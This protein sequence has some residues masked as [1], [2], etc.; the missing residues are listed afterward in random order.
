MRSTE[1]TIMKQYIVDAFTSELFSGNPAAVVI[2]AEPISDSL[3]NKIAAENNLSETAFAVKKA[4]KG[5]SDESVYNLR[6]IT[7]NGEIDLC[8][9]A[10]LATAFVISNFYE[11]PDKGHSN[12]GKRL[13]SFSTRSGLLTVSCIDDFYELNFPSFPLEKIDITPIM[14]DALGTKPVDAVLGRDL[15][16]VLKDEDTV[17][18]LNPDIEKVKNLVGVLCHVTALSS[19]NEYDCVSRS[20][21]PKHGVKED[22][23]CGSGH[24]HIA[25]YWSERLQ[26]T[27]IVGFQASMRGGV[28]HCDCSE[29]NRIKISGK[30]V[31]FSTCELNC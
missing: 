21:A 22:A 25:P 27:K 1:G 20:F 24:C 18:R 31:L 17:R 29:S 30:A 16:F 15:V 2:L 4:N 14:I 9:H 19:T 3:M 11:V 23:V 7:P 10:T 28:L 26:K 6:W 12:G 5:Q 13:L 8:G